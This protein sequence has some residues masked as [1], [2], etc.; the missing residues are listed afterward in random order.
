MIIPASS[1]KYVTRNTDGQTNKQRKQN[2]T[3]IKQTKKSPKKWKPNSNLLDGN[4]ED[5]K[6]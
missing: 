4:A 3:K 5:L 2:K 1:C 6:Y